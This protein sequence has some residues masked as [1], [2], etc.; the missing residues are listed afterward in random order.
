MNKTKKKWVDDF[1]VL[2][3]ID[4]KQ[5]LVTDQSPIQP[6]PFR[7]RH[8]QILPIQ[9]NTLQ[10]E[11]DSIVQYSEERKMLLN[12]IKTKTMIFNTLR[13]YDCVPQISIKD[14]EYL[15]VV[16]EHKILG[17]IVRSDLKTI[18][19]TENICKKGF[20]RM[21]ILRRL[22]SMGCPSKE[23]ITVLREQIIS[24]CEVGVAW[25]GPMITK[26]ESNM[27]ERILKTGLHIIFQENYSSFKNALRL[28]DMK[29]L[30]ERRLIHITNFSK[31][32]Y[33]NPRFKTWFCVDDQQPPLRFTRN[34]SKS[35]PLLK[36]VTCR[37]QRYA[38]SS[39]PVMTSI[40]SWHPPLLYTPYNL[41]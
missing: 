30:K 40:L 7:G 21:W 23:L 20:K 24:I 25:W 39:L 34:G 38:R 22:K 37:T 14:G 27:L 16:E 35:G 12:T 5:H 32:S 9:S 28:A 2:A 8:H 1:T 29:S 33:K 3:S 31:K 17:Q 26:H 41:A 4:L 15:E 10:P 11:I 6:V 13:N 19:N 18:S 36:P